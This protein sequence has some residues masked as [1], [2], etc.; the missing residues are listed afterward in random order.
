MHGRLLVYGGSG[1]TGKLLARAA[2]DRQIA[3]VL[4]G[5]SDE[6]L[7]AAAAS[8]DL[9]FRV[10][11]LEEPSKLAR[12]LEGIDV[13]INAAG[14]FS[15]TAPALVDACLRTGAHYLDVTGEVAVIDAIRRSNEQAIQRGVMLMPAVGF[16]VV[17]SDC[18]AEHV[19]RRARCARRLHIGISGLALLSKGSAKTMIGQ[20]GEPAWVRRGGALERVPA[21]SL[22][23]LFDY[24]GGPRTSVAVSWGDVVSAYFSTGIQDITVYF[25][26]TAAVRMHHTL[27]QL[28]G[29]AIPYT[30]WQAML[31]AS[32]EW[33]PDGPTEEERSVRQAVVVAEIEDDRGNV[34]ASRLR[35]PEV[36]SF[37]ASS[38]AAVAAR[39]VA[40]DIE[41][42]FQTPARVYGSDFVLSL[43]GVTR[44]D[45]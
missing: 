17:A 19:A 23:H 8:L 37:T 3:T 26:A 16:D 34:I 18:L 20:L 40:G 22:E 21:G 9:E 14:P 45:L 39:V 38:G 4:C 27:L 33:M 5:R 7:R 11:G 42:G 15:A 44:E 6:P 29:W 1:Y 13:V 32:T 41:P 31:K 10:A 43:P 25:E 30:P 24:G 28:F 35:T 2:R 36:Y 12:A